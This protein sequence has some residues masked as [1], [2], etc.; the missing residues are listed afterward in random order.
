M[1]AGARIEWQTERESKTKVHKLKPRHKIR[2]PKAETQKKAEL[3]N[4]KRINSAFGLWVSFGLRLSVFGFSA[5]S[6][7]ITLPEKEPSYPFSRH[8]YR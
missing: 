5:P 4:P 6:L 1:L 8:R 3:R 7:K 2:G